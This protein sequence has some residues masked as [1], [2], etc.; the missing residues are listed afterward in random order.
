MNASLRSAL[1]LAPPRLA[2]LIAL[3]AS[4]SIA[5]SDDPEPSPDPDT[6][7]PDAGDTSDAPDVEPPETCGNGQLDDGELCDGAL[8]NDATCQSLGFEGGTLTCASSCLSYDESGCDSGEPPTCERGCPQGYTCNAQGECAGGD[9]TDLTL[10][11]ITHTVSGEVRLDG[12]VPEFPHDEDD[13]CV[14]LEFVDEAHNVTISIYATCNNRGEPFTFEGQVYP[15]TY[16]VTVRAGFDAIPY[17]YRVSD[18]L[19]IDADTED[20]LFDVIS[21]PIAGELRHNGQVPHD[22]PGGGPNCGAMIFVDQQLHQRY[23]LPFT[24][25]PE[26]QPFTFEGRLP[27]GRFDVYVTSYQSE[28]LPLSVEGLVER[29]LQVNA[30]RT[31]LLFDIATHLVRGELLRNGEPPTFDDT[32]FTRCVNVHF[33]EPTLG[34]E[35]TQEFR[36]DAFNEGFDIEMLLYPGTYDVYVSGVGDVMPQL[37]GRIIEGLEVNADINDLTV[38]ATVHTIAGR[39]LKNGAAPTIAPGGAAF[40]AMLS[41]TDLE[42]GASHGIDL[43]CTDDAPFIFE[44]LMFES[45][46]ALAITTHAD[47]VTDVPDA[48]FLAHE[49][50]VVDRDLTDLELDVQTVSVSGEILE[51]GDIPEIPGNAAPECLYAHFVKPQQDYELQFSLA[52]TCDP[53]G[54]PAIFE[55]EVF[56]GTYKVYVSGSY[57][58]LPPSGYLVLDELTIDTDV[59]DLELDVPTRPLAG[60][61]LHNGEQPSYEPGT[62]PQCASVSFISLNDHGSVHIGGTCPTDGGAV[63]FDGEVFPGTY[64]V[65]LIGRWSDLPFYPLRVVDVLRVD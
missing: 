15:G 51:N 13:D 18:A 58:V 30:P 2:A 34:Y 35:F 12:E 5:C 6:A 48:P 42:G 59:S 43:P 57:G 29:D 21:H 36:C 52:A 63:R 60:Q 50:L 16:T 65:E 33:V 17:S 49:A 56:P 7:L 64:R 61:I 19:S 38:D 14:T 22:S 26:G 31:D 47:F 20:L 54:G 62:F 41:I 23:T 32:V 11:L 44:R 9:P 28:T 3:L 1:R 24:C 39:V 55:G 53:E 10:D 25:N 27:E 4:F 40:C 46:Y 45:T 37:R 8:L